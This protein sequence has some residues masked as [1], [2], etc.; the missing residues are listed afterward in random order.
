MEI[1]KALSGER[2]LLMADLSARTGASRPRINSRLQV[3]RARGVLDRQP[4]WPG[5]YFLL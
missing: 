1:I 3:L 2:G 4:G 5:R